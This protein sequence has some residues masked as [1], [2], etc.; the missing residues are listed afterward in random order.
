VGGLPGTGKST[1]AEAV[2]RA[3]GWAVLRSDVVRKELVGYDVVG[4]SETAFGTGMYQAEMTAA[5]YTELLARSGHLLR[6]GHSVVLDASWLRQ[7]WRDAA[8][9]LATQTTAKLTELRCRAPASVTE[10]RIVRR[11]AQG[12][13][14]SDATAPIARAMALASE[15]WPESTPIDTCGSP[16]QALDAALKA[17]R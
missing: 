9:D 14:P 13:D 16:D 17:A 4:K 7:C 15:L 3:T 5:V 8:R 11:A 10:S 12:Q 2:S 6:S 1:L